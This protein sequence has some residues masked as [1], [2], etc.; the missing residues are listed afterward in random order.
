M[1]DRLIKYIKR[2][3]NIVSIAEAMGDK[4]KAKLFKDS[5]AAGMDYEHE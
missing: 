5:F 4:G 3:L 2:K 1:K